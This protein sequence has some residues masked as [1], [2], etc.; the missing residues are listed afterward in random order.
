MRLTGGCDYIE[1]NIIPEKSI[2]RSEESVIDALLN[3][4]KKKPKEKGRRK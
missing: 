4:T 3:K 1:I 2:G